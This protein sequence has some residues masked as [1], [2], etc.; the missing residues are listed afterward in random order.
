MLNSAIRLVV[1]DNDEGRMSKVGT[2]HIIDDDEDVRTSL[3]QLVRSAGYATMT[4]GSL[5]TF[6]PEAASAALG[7]V[8]LDVRMPGANGLEFQEQLARDG[9]DLSVIMMTG[10][11]DIPMSVRAMKAGAVDFLPKPF[12]DDQMLDAISAAISRDLRRFTERSASAEIAARYATLTPRERQVM[13]LVTAGKL[14][15]QSAYELGLSEIT[16]KVHRR[17]AMTK[18]QAASLADLVKMAQ[19]LPVSQAEQAALDDPA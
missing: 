15:K 5:E 6:V 16:V 17:S 3:D 2:V 9:C 18:M 4:Y 10:H 11:G 13:A 1:M 8:L 12:D 19:S 7:C 14:N